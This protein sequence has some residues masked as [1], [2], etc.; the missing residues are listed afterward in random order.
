MS[1]RISSSTM[2]HVRLLTRLERFG[3]V[4]ICEAYKSEGPRNLAI[5]L[6][7]RL[8]R[9]KECAKRVEANEE[10]F[11]GHF[12][13]RSGVRVKLSDGVLMRRKTCR[14]VHTPSNGMFAIDMLG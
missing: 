11:P 1:I 12:W 4:I 3:Y 13:C 6:S 8:A 7:Y 2:S 9:R 10:I 14:K 5:L